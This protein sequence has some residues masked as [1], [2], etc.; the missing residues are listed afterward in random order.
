MTAGG[1]VGV[2]R[3]AAVVA[4]RGRNPRGTVGAGRGATGGSKPEGISGAGRAGV[5]WRSDRGGVDVEKDLT[6]SV[7]VVIWR[8][9]N[10]NLVLQRGRC[11]DVDGW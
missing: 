2:V 8:A 10:S 3:G 9:H 5:G 4:A 7:S 6:T 11:S 1:T